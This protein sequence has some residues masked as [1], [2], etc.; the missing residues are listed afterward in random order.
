MRE[1]GDLDDASSEGTLTADKGLRFRHMKNMFSDMDN[2][3]RKRILTE[4]L[5]ECDGK[6]LGFVANVV[7]P[8]LKRDP[9]GVLP[10][11]LCLRV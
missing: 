5:G 2:D 6:L 3:E 4:L 9:F 7:A 8:R 11:E 1:D 10:N